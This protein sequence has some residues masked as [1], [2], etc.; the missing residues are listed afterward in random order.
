MTDPAMRIE[1][2]DM[3]TEE[4]HLFQRHRLTVDDY[5]RMGE[6]GIL[7]PDARVE[8]IEGEIIDMPPIGISHAAAVDSLARKLVLAMGERAIV[9]VQNP[10]RLDRY[11][12]PVA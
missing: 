2:A 7:A 4:Q 10:V 6:A 5:Y 11:S 8:L 1:D 12:E 9:R 3:S